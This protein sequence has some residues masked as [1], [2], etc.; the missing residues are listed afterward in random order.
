MPLAELWISHERRRQYAEGIVFD[1]TAVGHTDTTFN[2]WRGF[3]VEPRE[4]SWEQLKDH[5]RTVICG[6]NAERCG[7]L[8]DWL[9]DVVQ[10]PAKQGEVAIVL[11]RPEGCGKGDPPTPGP[12]HGTHPIPL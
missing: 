7:Y 3:A 4:G 6:G 8:L 1:P 9:A 10:H 5:V 2:L 11:C 12:R